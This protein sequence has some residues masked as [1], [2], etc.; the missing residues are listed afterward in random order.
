MRAHYDRLS[1]EAWADRTAIQVE[2]AERGER[3]FLLRRF[4]RTR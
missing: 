1:V 2:Q 4:E 3:K